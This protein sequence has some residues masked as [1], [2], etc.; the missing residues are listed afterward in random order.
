MLAE[1]D[2]TG[3]RRPHRVPRARQ[4]AVE[5]FFD[6]LASGSYVVHHVHGVARYGGMVTRAIGGAERDYLLLEYRGGDKLYVPS[7]QIDTITP[8]SGGEQPALNRLN[9]GEWQR[10]RARV[11]AAVREVAQ[12]LVVLYQRRLATPGHAFAPDTPWQAELEQTLP[13]SRDARPAAGDRGRE[14]GHGAAG[15]DGPPGVRRRRLRQ[16]R[17]RRARRVQGRPGR[18]AGRRAR[19]DD[20]ARPAALPDLRR[21]LRPLPGAR[22][23]A[24]RASSP[25]ARPARWSAGLADGSVDVVVGT[26]RLLA[27]DV[28]FKDLG[29]LVVDEEQRFGVIAQGGDQAALA[30]ASTCSPSPPARSRAPWRWAS[31]GS[32]TCR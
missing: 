20:A 27:G 19:A 7:D 21:A 5:G 29:L 1:P 15:A 16:D 10:S 3:R 17:G 30:S 8:Y 26:H 4:R 2:L 13:L 18:Q 28:A 12:E 9:G 11:R 25:P 6:D 24:R 23:D 32:A 14:G 22:R 31:P